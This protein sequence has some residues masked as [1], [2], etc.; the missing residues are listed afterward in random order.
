MIKSPDTTAP[1]QGGSSPS[2]LFAQLVAECA[3]FEQWWERYFTRR[4]QGTLMK[5]WGHPSKE[6][7]HEGWRGNEY[8]YGDAQDI[9]EAWLA[10]KANT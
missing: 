10:S 9:F 7:W 6:G 8:Y 5:G 2:P 3:A 4:G 1:S